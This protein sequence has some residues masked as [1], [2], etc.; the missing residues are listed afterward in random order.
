MGRPDQARLARRSI[1]M[2]VAPTRMPMLF[3][4][5]RQTSDVHVYDVPADQSFEPL[6][7]FPVYEYPE[8]VVVD[9]AS[10]CVYVISSAYGQILGMKVLQGSTY[11]G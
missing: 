3:V 11:Y 8:D 1:A 9:A 7:S 4:T 2:S 5:G 6:G 10:E